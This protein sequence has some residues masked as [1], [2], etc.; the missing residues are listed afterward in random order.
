MRTIPFLTLAISF[1]LLTMATVTSCSGGFNSSSVGGPDGGGNGP[2]GSTTS[3]LSGP[4]TTLI[5][6]PPTT[7]VVPQPSITIPI[8]SG[9]NISCSSLAGRFSSARQIIDYAGQTGNAG[10]C[11]FLNGAQIQTGFGPCIDCKKD[12]WIPPN[13]T[14]TSTTTSLPPQTGW[15]T[16]TTIPGGG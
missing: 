14:T 12:G 16:T 8:P 4:S 2:Q 9:G 1:T 7:Q 13:S 5:G 11:I 10:A 15:T 6:G 3:T